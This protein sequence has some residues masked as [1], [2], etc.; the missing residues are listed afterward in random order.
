MHYILSGERQGKA[1]VLSLPEHVSYD[2]K[3]VCIRDMGAITSGAAYDSKSK[4]EAAAQEYLEARKA[5]RR[6]AGAAY[7]A[8]NPGRSY[9]RDLRF[10][11]P[12]L[13]TT[14][15]LAASSVKPIPIPPSR[16]R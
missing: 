6:G 15:P 16:K 10:G 11:K 9:E 12:R 14:P 1:L 8:E 4:A 5:G 2:A 3:G 13:T 7:E